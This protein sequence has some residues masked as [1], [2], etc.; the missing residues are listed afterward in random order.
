MAVD[1]TR[2]KLEEAIERILNGTPLRRKKNSGI[3]PYGVEVEA[4]VGIGLLKKND[5]Y[6]DILK[7]IEELKLEQS[8]TKNNSNDDSGSSLISAEKLINEL[9]QKLETRLDEIRS[10]REQ[11]KVLMPTNA[12]LILL[13]SQRSSEENMREFIRSQSSE[14]VVNLLKNK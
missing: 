3:S 6:S 13:L 12:E 5:N 8:Y 4:G 10:L 11:N 7:R 2:Q 9:K 1:T 14:N